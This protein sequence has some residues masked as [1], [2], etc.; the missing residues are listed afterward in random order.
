MNL[1]SEGQHIAAI[2]EGQ[3]GAVLTPDFVLCRGLATEGGVQAGNQAGIRKA[4][5][6]EL[7][8]FHVSPIQDCE[9]I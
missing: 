4:C 2:S 9:H 5:C 1:H 7:L 6:L 3:S 8:P